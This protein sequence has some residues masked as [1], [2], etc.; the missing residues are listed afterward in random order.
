MSTFNFKI[1]FFPIAMFLATAPI[2][3]ADCSHSRTQS[4]NRGIKRGPDSSVSLSP[5]R[6]KSDSTTPTKRAPLSDIT[7]IPPNTNTAQETES[8]KYF[9]LAQDL[10]ADMA[11]MMSFAEGHDCTLNE[12]RSSVNCQLFGSKQNSWERPQ[13]VIEGRFKKLDKNPDPDP[14]TDIDV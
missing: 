6:F 5:K 14:D 3:G 10:D 8:N 7:T 12:L 1:I 9:L 4:P 13:E 2:H 11:Q